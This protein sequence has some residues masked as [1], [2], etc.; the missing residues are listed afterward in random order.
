MKDDVK[1]IQ[2]AHLPLSNFET[3]CRQIGTTGPVFFAGVGV[4]INAADTESVR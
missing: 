3:H 2:M 4:D 1:K